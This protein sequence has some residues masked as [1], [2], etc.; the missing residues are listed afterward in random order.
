MK[1]QLLNNS[2]ML[3]MVERGIRREIFHGI[4]RYAKANNKYIKIRTKNHHS[5]YLKQ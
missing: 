5:S 2:N 3:S 4:R 1:L